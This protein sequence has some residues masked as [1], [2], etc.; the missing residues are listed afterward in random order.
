MADRIKFTLP[1]GNIT[2][3]DLAFSQV[4]EALGELSKED[5]DAF[6]KR[7]REV[8]LPPNTERPWQ[9]CK[10]WLVEENV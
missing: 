8:D 6:W 7:E 5:Q 4:V 2:I 9:G 10:A 3:R 1:N